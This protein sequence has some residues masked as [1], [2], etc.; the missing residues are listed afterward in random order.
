MKRKWLIGLG[1]ALIIAVLLSP[2]ASSDPDGLE[3]VA[4]DKG[5]LE[6]GFS[7]LQSPIPDY[8]FPGIENEK[9]ATA[10]AGFVGTALTFGVMLGLGKLVVSRNKRLKKQTD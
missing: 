6:E 3:R 7:Y 2:F 9:L 5:Y 8:L 1:V 10:A 4:E